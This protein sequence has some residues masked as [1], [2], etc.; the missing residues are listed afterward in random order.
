[1]KVSV[2]I[3]IDTEH[4]VGGALQDSS[5]KPVGNERRIFGKIKNKE[6]GIPLI[7]D[8]AERH[9]ISLTFFVEV[10]SRSYFG[11]EETSRVC[12]Y[13]LNRGHDI[14]LHLHPLFLNFDSP[15]PADQVYK[16]TMTSY[17]LH[18]QTEMIRDGKRLLFRYGVNNLI[19]FRAGGFAANLD[20]L[21]A[22]QE[23]GFLIDSS[24]NRYYLR[25]HCKLHALD[26]NDIS[27]VEGIWEI[28]VTN[29]FEFL[30]LGGG[31]P[32]PLDINGISFLEMK[33]IL[34]SALTDGPFNITF[35][36]HSFSF[37]HNSG[38]ENKKARPRYQVIRRFEQLCRFLSDNAENYTVRTFG[39]LK[40]YELSVMNK[41]ANH[42]LPRVSSI[43][44]II[45]LFEQA[46][47]RIG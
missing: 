15:N 31:R 4:S 40:Q 43:L 25:T 28:P 16:P 9:S 30:V 12:E 23:N 20:T 45:R 32:K 42:I 29:F 10:F 13:I 19:A 35:L 27:E 6:Y 34:R 41:K 8:I 46:K 18:T 37:V 26:I 2:F 7:M 21:K 17:D 36:M 1:M 14:Q 33:S 22:L 5:L 39:S 24:L 11:E 38:V 3:T 44:S 47:E